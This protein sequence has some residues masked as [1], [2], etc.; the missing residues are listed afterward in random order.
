[1]FVVVM[2]ANGLHYSILLLQVTRQWSYVNS[3]A[4]LRLELVA[5]IPVAQV[6]IVLDEGA[7]DNQSDGR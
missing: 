4:T 6:C 1:M 5:H 2:L 7:T 3:V